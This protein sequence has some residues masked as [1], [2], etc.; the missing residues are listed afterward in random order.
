MRKPTSSRRRSVKQ[1]EGTVDNSR[2]G[3]LRRLLAS[4]PGLKLA[5]E[6]GVAPD[7]T[8]RRALGRHPGA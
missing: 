5:S 8:R 7:L 2:E 1:P 6:I 3:R 4:V